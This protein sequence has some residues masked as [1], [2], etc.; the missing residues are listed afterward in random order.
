[1]LFQSPSFCA[2]ASSVAG[3]RVVVVNIATTGVF[4]ETAPALAAGAHERAERAAE[5]V[6]VLA[7]RRRAQEA[8]ESVLSGRAAD[9]GTVNFCIGLAD[10]LSSPTSPTSYA[11]SAGANSWFASLRALSCARFC[12][13]M[14]AV[15]LSRAAAISGLRKPG[16]CG[17]S[18]VPPRAA[19]APEKERATGLC[20]STPLIPGCASCSS[21]RLSGDTRPG[22]GNRTLPAG[23]IWLPWRTRP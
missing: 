6:R 11:A 18:P 16:L 7:R 15:S 5:V 2:A 13:S 21:R 20:G 17:S 1:V 14:P 12:A 19:A 4:Y 8:G 23:T 3:A 10:A 9:T 22:S